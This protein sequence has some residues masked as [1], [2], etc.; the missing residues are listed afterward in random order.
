MVGEDEADGDRRSVLI[1]CNDDVVTDEF[2]GGADSDDDNLVCA[3][4][5]VNRC[6]CLNV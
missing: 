1:R 6:C 2:G 5:A 4:I 3:G